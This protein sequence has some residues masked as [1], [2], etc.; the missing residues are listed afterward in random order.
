MGEIAYCMMLARKGSKMMTLENIIIYMLKMYPTNLAYKLSKARITKMVYL[1]DWKKCISSG[2]Q[3]TNIKWYFDNY[4]PF[5]FDVD[6]VINKSD[7]IESI[8]EY[9]IYGNIKTNY[10]LKNRS[11]QVALPEEDKKIIDFVINETKTLSWNDFIS[12][13]YSTHPIATSQRYSVLNLEKKAEEYNKIME[14]GN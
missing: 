1:T 14:E 13:V 9:T 12:L 8:K 11:I 5:V 6:D 3:M 10:V 2:K 4:G 7:Y